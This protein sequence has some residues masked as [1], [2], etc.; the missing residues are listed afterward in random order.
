MRKILLI[1][2]RARQS[3]TA[4]VLMSKPT[5]TF[6]YKRIAFAA[7]AAALFGVAFANTDEA[8]EPVAR[9]ASY[10]PVGRSTSVP[11]GWVVFGGRRREECSLGML[12]PVDVRLNKKTWA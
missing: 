3:A 12:N 5:G 1:F 7:T 11:Y 9:I 4:K 10:A 6:M 2:F 8:S